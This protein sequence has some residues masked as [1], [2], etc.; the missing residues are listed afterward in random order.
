MNNEKQL[1]IRVG[2]MV[3]WYD[4]WYA[5]NEVD[6]TDPD[7]TVYWCSD[8]DGVERDLTEADVDVIDRDGVWIDRD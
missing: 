5:V 1:D 8:Q 3:L 2:D 4:T 6:T 7:N